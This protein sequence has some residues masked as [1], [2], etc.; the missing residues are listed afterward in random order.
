MSVDIAPVLS[1]LRKVQGW[2]WF[3]LVWYYL[4]ATYCRFGTTYLLHIVG[5]V[6]LTCYILQVWYHLPATYCRFGTTYLIHIVGLVPPTCYILQV[7]YYLP[8]TYCR[9][10][11][12]YLL[13]IV[14][15]VLPTCYI[16]Q[17]W[18]STIC[19]PSYWDVMRTIALKKFFCRLGRS[20]YRKSLVLQTN[21]H[22]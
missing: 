21:Y 7:W 8:A 11:T 10:G 19:P 17:V 18:F 6:L 9:F 20:S 4:P 14:G 15:L 13:H 16:L 22:L 12:T 1:M 2:V 5:L 3:G